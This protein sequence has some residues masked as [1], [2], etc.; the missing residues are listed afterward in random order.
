MTRQSNA[1]A[2]TT[3]RGA[4]MTLGVL[5]LASCAGTDNPFSQP[6]AELEIDCDLPSDL[7]VDGGA[8]GADAIPAL[9]LPVMVS[10]D[11]QEELDYLR[12]DDR[13]MGLFMNGEARAYPH[14][15]F[16][17]HEVINDRIGG[18]NVAIT[19]CPLTGS[20]LVFD[21]NI[22]G[23]T[24]EFGVSGLLWANNLILF[25]RETREIYGPQ[26]S[27]VGRCS[28]FKGAQPS[29]I[30]VTETTWARWKQ[31]Y[32]STTVVSGDTQF[33][34]PYE[35]YPYGGYDQLTNGSLLF[36][37]G[38][39][40][41]RPIKE[42]VLGIRVGE[43][44][45]KGY[46]FGELEDLGFVSVV[47]DNVGGSD[48]VVFYEAANRKSAHAF[49]RSVDGQTL[50]FEVVNEV[51]KDVETGSSWDLAGRAIAGPLAVAG[52]ELDRFDN[53]YTLFWFAWRHFQPNGDVFRAS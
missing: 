27:V 30:A 4:G 18:Q 7:L 2:R 14:N 25:D 23:R 22:N 41:S 31:L 29:L 16:W 39:D 51:Y 11:N 52:M 26:L 6:P 53:A 24:I 43:D 38:T 12:D 42:R 21:P 47:N 33:F 32:P 9:S 46:P 28:A 45:G 35:I 5:L 1:G 40:N 3:V 37:M 50:T 20:G 34:R 8:G 19:F 49:S 15:I 17:Y 48:I 36:P 10:A 44:G 13:V